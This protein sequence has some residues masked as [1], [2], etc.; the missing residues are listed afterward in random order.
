MAALR[1]ACA[2]GRAASVPW[3]LD[4]QWTNRYPKV[5]GFSHH[6][7]LEGYELPTLGKPWGPPLG[8]PSVIRYGG[9]AA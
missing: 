9:G 6:V 8:G 3:A 4:A 5:E 2:I 7:Y 1:V